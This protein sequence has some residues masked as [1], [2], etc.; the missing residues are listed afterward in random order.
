VLLA[1]RLLRQLAERFQGFT[2]RRTEAFRLADSDRQNDPE[3]T[4]QK[5]QIRNRHCASA[6]LQ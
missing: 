3:F 2:L 1:L 4:I 6:V 5:S